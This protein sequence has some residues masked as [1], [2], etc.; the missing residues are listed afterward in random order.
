MNELFSYTAKDLIFN[1]FS[2][3]SNFRNLRVDLEISAGEEVPRLCSVRAP[4]TKR[5][6]G[7]KQNAG[8]GEK[9]P[10]EKFQT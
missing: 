2:K 6:V 9:V 10:A 4:S 8:R 3:F 5:V 7:S 1:Q